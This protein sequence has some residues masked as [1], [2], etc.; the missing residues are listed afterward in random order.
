MWK[1]NLKKSKAEMEHY[2]EQYA[3]DLKGLTYDL[4]SELQE[5]LKGK[6][7]SGKLRRVFKRFGIDFDDY[8]IE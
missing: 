2:D 6:V 8:N 5:V 3:E 4:I 7:T 1:D